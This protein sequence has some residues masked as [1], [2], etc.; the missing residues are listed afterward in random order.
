M[1]YGGVDTDTAFGASSAFWRFR[2]FVMMN[3][4][5]GKVPYMRVPPSRAFDIRSSLLSADGD[6]PVILG[7]GAILHAAM[8]ASPHMRSR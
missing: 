3:F 1:A 8:A 4:F 6:D 7:S 5:S 2:Q